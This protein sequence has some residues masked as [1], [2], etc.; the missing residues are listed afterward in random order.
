MG[1]TVSSANGIAVDNSISEYSYSEEANSI[2]P[3]AL[4]GGSGAANVTLDGVDFTVDAGIAYI[5]S[6]MT[7]T[8]GTNNS[9]VFKVNGVNKTSDGKVALNGDTLTNKL[10]IEVTAAPQGNTSLKNAIN[11]YCGLA[12]ITPQ[13]D[14]SI[15]S[16]LGKTVNFIGWKGNLWEHLKMLCAG[17]V[18]NSGAHI[19]MYVLN[20]VLRFRKA[21]DS[22]NL[23]DLSD[24]VSSEDIS[25]DSTNL[26]QK[27]EMYN[28]NTSYKTPTTGGILYEDKELES[29]PAGLRTYPATSGVIS[30]N[31]GETSVTRVKVKASLTSVQQPTAVTTMGNPPYSGSTSRYVVV[32]PDDVVIQ[33]SAWEAGYVGGR[34]KVA[35]VGDARDELE[36]TVVAPPAP[37]STTPGGDGGQGGTGN[38]GVTGLANPVLSFAYGG[39]SGT[40]SASASTFNFSWTPVAN[41]EF[42]I[43]N[44]VPSS[45]SAQTYTFTNDVTS[46]PL[47]LLV[48]KSYTVT[49]TAGTNNALVNGVPNSYLLSS[50]SPYAFFAAI[51]DPDR[52]SG[53]GGSSTGGSTVSGTGPDNTVAQPAVPGAPE[54][55]TSDPNSAPTTLSFSSYKVGIET[56]G[57]GS[58]YPAFYIVGT[59]VFYDKQMTSISTGLTSADTT[60]DVGTTIDNPFI[61]TTADFNAKKALALKKFDTPKV[62]LS[63][64]V[65]APR[66]FGTL[67]G[68]TQI[69]D[70]ATFRVESV[71]YSPSD[72][73][74]TS[75][76]V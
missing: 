27:I 65:A 21:L 43:L 45:G 47:G 70:G 76:K 42:Y 13:Y 19:E 11:Y 1:I 44:V 31:A 4:T 23:I 46:Y 52:G 41:A 26:A 69:V 48:S 54:S 7:L 37:T 35:I 67:P 62:T 38:S 56:A 10:N 63:Q 32:G 18:S 15:T 34:V 39:M 24:E 14:A 9:V 55:G 22:A 68:S 6:N 2:E 75:S 30:V 5:G 33:P 74:I 60:T 73:S 16:D 71:S 57:S 51:S 3:S 72:V 50:P 58:D 49:V 12:G 29:G 64:S 61:T 17:V 28:Y 59:G 25:F 40:G 36:I 53:G 8:D 66:T 20:G